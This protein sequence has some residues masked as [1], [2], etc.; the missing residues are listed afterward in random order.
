MAPDQPDHLAPE[1]RP[2]GP[3]PAA[4]A[5][6]PARARRTLFGEILD[7]LLVPLM[8]LWP[9]S[10]VLTYVSAKSISNP[11]YDR[12]LGESAQVL[13][14]QLRFRNGRVIADLPLPARDIL[15]TEDVDTV[16]F[17][18]LGT[19]REL[20]AGDRELPLP[21]DDEVMAS[22]QVR[23]RNAILHGVEVR[24]AYIYTTPVGMAHI[25]AK[26]R[27]SLP[28]VQVAETLNKRAQLAN[29]IVKGVILPQ[30]IVLPLAVTLVWFGLVRGLVPLADLSQRIGRRKPGDLSPIEQGAVPEE[31]AP[32]IRSINQ[33]MARLDANLK[34]HQRF[35][36]NAAHQLRTPLAGLKTQ[37]E[38]ALRQSQSD[39]DTRELQ[40]SLRQMALSTERAARMVNQLLALTR[41]E[42]GHESDN[43]PTLQRVR[44]D[45]LVRDCVHDWVGAALKKRIDLGCDE[46]RE[47]AIEV[48]GDAVLLR[49]MVGNLI[50][51]AI[52]YT[53]DGGVITA[54]LKCPAG[55]AGNVGAVLEVE[56]N[57]PGIPEHERELVFER[58][59][60]VLGS[61]PDGRNLDGSGL[62]LAIVREIAQKHHAGVTVGERAGGGALFTIMFP[63]PA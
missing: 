13:A 41:A 16:Y 11:P 38:L 32:L 43:L 35:V 61:D 40:A 27:Q 57:G 44:L 55:R 17:Q 54:R 10:I 50:D 34:G 30:F 14:E 19:R 6:G 20:L 47:D 58:F 22:D 62:G 33:L 36:A 45:T 3:V 28:L 8:L 37:T 60:R 9:V 52:R 46:A 24:I 4:A 5:P 53:P 49:E 39:T 31:V 23:F 59:Y 42:R 12:A 15:R 21:E 29:E 25:D 1:A 56:D 63:R 7:W 18:V 2:A 26:T 51:N 48:D